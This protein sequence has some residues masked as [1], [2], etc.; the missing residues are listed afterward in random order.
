MR[1]TNL[2]FACLMFASSLSLTANAHAGVAFFLETCVAAVKDF[3]SLEKRLPALGM[4]ESNDVPSRALG[5][6]KSTRTW[7]SNAFPGQ[8]GDGFVQHVTGTRA[9]PFEVCTHGSRPGEPATEALAK[10]QK[11]YPPLEGVQR[12]T[13][14]FYGGVE[15]WLAKIEGIDVLLRVGWAFLNDPSSGSSELVLIKPLIGITRHPRPIDLAASTCVTKAGR[16][17]C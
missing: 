6:P 2:M 11:L 17:V 1:C 5:K 4:K 13:H 14:F 12:E 7:T 15:T 9:E 3:S 10:L 8:P 16:R